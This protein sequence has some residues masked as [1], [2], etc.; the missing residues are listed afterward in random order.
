MCLS[1]EE[2][3]PNEGFNFLEWGLVA[4]HSGVFFD[5]DGTL[6]I[7]EPLTEASVDQLLERVGV[8]M[9][10]DYPQLHGIPWQSIANHLPRARTPSST[11]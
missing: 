6:L 10:V 3:T 2:R 8:T 5:M 9:D 4:I 11:M 1:I 7:P